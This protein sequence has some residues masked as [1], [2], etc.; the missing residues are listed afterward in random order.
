MP[1]ILGPMMGNRSNRSNKAKS[2]VA[3]ESS[4]TLKALEARISLT[5]PRHTLAFRIDLSAFIGNGH[6]SLTWRCL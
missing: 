1:G 4:G 2:R 3:E 5:W 6:I